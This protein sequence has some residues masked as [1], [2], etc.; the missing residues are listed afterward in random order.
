MTHK[1]TG[2]QLHILQH[3]LGLDEFGLGKSYRNHF[4]TGPDCDDYTT[5]NGLVERGLMSARKVSFLHKVDVCFVVTDLGRSVV[6]AESPAPP[7]RTRSQRRYLQYLA[8]DSGLS[9]GEWIKG[10]GRAVRP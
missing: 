8:A 4:V 1:L 9:F 5:C 3:A 6:Q 2:Q 10:D 7:K